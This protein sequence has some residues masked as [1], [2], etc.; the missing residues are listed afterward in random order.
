MARIARTYSRYG[1][2]AVSVL[3]Q[4][5]RINRLERQLSVAD[6]AER[7]GVSRDMLRR[8]ESGDPRCT[9]GAAFEAASIVG[10]TL[11]EEDRDKLTLRIAEQEAKLR[12]LPKA[13]HKA[14]TAVKDDF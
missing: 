11:F 8:I 9:I 10:V 4:Q 12:L 6:L 7:V 2:E 1:R 13:I 14:R 5:I 3:G